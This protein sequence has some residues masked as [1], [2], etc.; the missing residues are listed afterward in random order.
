MKRSNDTFS[1]SSISL[2]RPALRAA[3]SATSSPSLCGGLH[4]LLAVLVGAGQEEHV[5]AVEPLKARQRVGRDRLIGVADMRRAV[6]IGDRGRDVVGVALG[7]DRRLWPR[8]AGF[9]RGLAGFARSAT[10]DCRYSGVRFLRRYRA[11]SSSALL[12]DF[13]ATRLLGRL[14]WLLS[15]QP[16]WL[17]SARPSLQPSSTPCSAFFT[18]R[19]ALGRPFLAARFFARLLAGAGG[20]RFADLLRLALF[21]S[22]LSS[23]RHHE[24]LF[25]STISGIIVRRRVTASLPR[26]AQTPRKP[27]VFVPD[28]R[29]RCRARRGRSFPIPPPAVQGGA[30][31]RWRRR[32]AAFRRSSDRRRR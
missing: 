32:C 27:A 4:H 7:S 23:L 31:S 9:A 15:S 12:A 10:G 21:R 24:F 18:V 13:F 5:L 2:K 26:A 3:S 17:T 22:F 6:R 29:I 14:S 19:F 30:D 8:A 11:R 28:C 1:R 20:R 25:N 16:S